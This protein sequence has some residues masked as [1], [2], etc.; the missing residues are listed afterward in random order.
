MIAA[1]GA[2]AYAAGIFHLMTHAF[3]KALLFLAAGS[4]IIAMHHDQDIRNM[5]G[6][7]RWMPITWITALIGSLALIAFPGF[8]GFFSKDA[9]IEAVGHSHIAGSGLAT[10]LLTVGAFIT[11]LYSFRLYFLVFHGEPRMDAHTRSH[12]HETPWVVTVPLIAL[13]IPSV[14]IGWHAIEPLLVQNWLGDAIYVKPDH[15]TLHYLAE[16]WHGQREFIRHGM[17]MAPFW[18]SM[19]GLVVAAYVWWY[20]HRRNPGIDAELQRRGGWLT[21]V[22][23]DKYGFDD[24]NQRVFAN[25]GQ[26]IGRFLWTAS[27]RR[28]IDDAIVNGSARAVGWLAGRMRHLQSGM[29]YHYAFAMIVGLVVLLTLFVTF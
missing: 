1:L 14:F 21:R 23:E 9:I 8:S 15:D 10:L 18:L 19:G 13:A 22:L 6:L 28:F 17:Q 3:F 24:F 11:A 27:D 25:G 29:L 2:S 5:G 20:Q 26:R 16:H 7:K 4:V 12:L